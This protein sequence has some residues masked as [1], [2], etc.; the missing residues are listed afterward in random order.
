MCLW[1]PATAI[2]LEF[3]IFL[4]WWAQFC[5]AG[6]VSTVESR[7]P[8]TSHFAETKTSGALL[9]VS[10]I[11]WKERPVEHLCISVLK[12]AQ[13]K[14]KAHDD[15]RSALTDVEARLGLFWLG[16]LRGTLPKSHS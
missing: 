4:S 5:N 9:V 8:K 12:W 16:D 11:I 6:Y 3:P 7:V 15:Q 2:G 13:W 1:V 10:T 14:R